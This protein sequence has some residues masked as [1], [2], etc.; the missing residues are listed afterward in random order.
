MHLAFPAFLF[1]ESTDDVGAGIPFFQLT[2]RRQHD[3]L[4][5]DDISVSVIT[6]TEER[7]TFHGKDRKSVV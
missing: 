2:G 3:I 7:R 5:V 6:D 4:S 1:V